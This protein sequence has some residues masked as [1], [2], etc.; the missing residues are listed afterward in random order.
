MK[1]SCLFHLFKK[2]LAKYELNNNTFLCTFGIKSLKL[3]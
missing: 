1:V 3:V 2:Y